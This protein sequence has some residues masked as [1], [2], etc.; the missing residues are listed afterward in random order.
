MAWSSLTNGDLL[1]LIQG[2]FN[3]FITIDGSIVFQQ[4][5]KD[6]SFALIVLSAP[7]NQL[8]HL[9][10]LIPSILKALETIQPG[11]VVNISK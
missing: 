7:T 3:V 11:Q 2:K 8:E 5:L 4:H 6:L 10:P 1:N 9:E